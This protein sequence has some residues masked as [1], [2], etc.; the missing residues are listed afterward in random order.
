MRQK[1]KRMMSILLNLMMVLGL[2]P[3]MSLTAYA[4]DPYASIKRTTTVVNF[5]SKD[6][7][8]IDYDSSTVTLLAKECVAALQY[9]SSGTFVDYSSNPTVKNA[10]D[11][12]YN[13]ISADAKIAVSGDGMFL[14]TEDQAN[15]ISNADVRKCQRFT[16]T[17]P[18][19]WWL[20]TE[21]VILPMRRSSTAIKAPLT[22]S[23]AMC[24]TRSAS[25]LL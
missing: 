4:D 16:G 14:L 13:S 25:A 2:M 23:A 8:L 5:D 7:Y 18:N 3:G 22:T 1:M 10:V 11:T 6:W 9:N 19:G 20:C 17:D 12:Y 15:G 24:E 21:V